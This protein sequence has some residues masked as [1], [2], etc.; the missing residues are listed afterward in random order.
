MSTNIKEALLECSDI[1]SNIMNNVSNK[2]DEKGMSYTHNNDSEIIVNNST[3]KDIVDM[4]GTME[5]IDPN[6]SKLMLQVTES[7]EKVFIRQKFI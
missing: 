2:L 4:L 5:N 1:I 6:K 7:N 3:K